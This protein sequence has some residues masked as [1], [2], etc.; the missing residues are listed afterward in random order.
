MFVLWRAKP[1]AVLGQSGDWIPKE[2]V[3]EKL[4]EV[5]FF[6]N[7]GGARHIQRSQYSKKGV[8]VLGEKAFKDKT[9][10]RKLP[11]YKECSPQPAEKDDRVSQPV[12]YNEYLDI[13][14]EGDGG[15]GT[16]IVFPPANQE[17]TVETPYIQEIRTILHQLEGYLSKI[18]SQ[19]QRL[20][21][22]IKQLDLLI[23]DRLHQSELFAL[24]DEECVAFVQGL[25]DTQI[26]RRRRKNEL[27]ALHACKDLL[28]HTELSEVKLALREIDGLGQKGYRCRVLTDTDP[29]IQQHIVAKGGK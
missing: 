7:A 6:E 13:L 11:V 27:T 16:R 20:S 26:E 5:R 25:H 12:T 2:K 23:S 18:D 29:F 3:A 28:R 24:S 10:I 19:E 14:C 9:K 15:Q 4:N 22:E 8:S 17:N 21:N 1:A